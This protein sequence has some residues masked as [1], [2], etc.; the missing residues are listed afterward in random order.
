MAK[1]YSYCGK[2]KRNQEQNWLGH[3]RKGQNSHKN[4][5][6]NKSVKAVSF[7][8]PFEHTVAR[9]DFN[10]LQNAIERTQQNFKTFSKFSLL[11]NC[12]FYFWGIFCPSI[13]VPCLAIGTL[14]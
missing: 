9:K 1:R 4:T 3:R 8:I 13:G 7:N 2:T 5:E 11:I 12:G 6:E 10:L 14:F